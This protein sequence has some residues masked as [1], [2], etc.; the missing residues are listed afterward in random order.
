MSDPINPTDPTNAPQT[1]PTPDAQ[2]PAGPDVRVFV[3]DNDGSGF[4]ASVTVPAGTT[5]MGL[6]RQRKPDQP[7]SHFT[8]RVKRLVNA[9]TPRA[10]RQVYGNVAADNIE[11][12]PEDFVLQDGDVFSTMPQKVDAGR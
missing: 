4:A 1:T 11:P 7:P 8:I 10:A 5:A 2:A 6:F 3:Y 9:D 12:L